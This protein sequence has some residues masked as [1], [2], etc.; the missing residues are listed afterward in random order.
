[1]EAY[2]NGDRRAFDELFA[3]LA[4]RVMLTL[5]RL[6]RSRELAEEL[7]QVTFLKVHRARETYIP[8]SHV[9]PW[10]TAIA[11]NVYIDAYRAGRNRKR[12]EL[13]TTEGTLPEPDPDDSPS[14][15]DGNALDT[16]SDEDQRILQETI[17]AL[18]ANQ[19]EALLMLKV[20]GLSLKQ[21]AAAT[22]STVGA[23]K[24]RAHRAYEALREALGAKKKSRPPESD[25]PSN[26]PTR[27]R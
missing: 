3:Q 12:R 8:G 5:M 16:L 15:G 11:R 25:E 22:G 1:M 18:P 7:T 27:N 17:D 19:R 4:P 23:V 24:L 21:I 2:C 10:V 26:H 9:L 6:S 13:L 20:E 14:T